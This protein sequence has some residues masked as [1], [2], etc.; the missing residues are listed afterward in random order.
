MGVLD[1]ECFPGSERQLLYVRSPIFGQTPWRAV[2]SAVY[3]TIIEEVASAQGLRAPLPSGA[4]AHGD[5]GDA[6]EYTPFPTASSWRRLF[7]GLVVLLLPVGRASPACISFRGGM[8][9][10]GDVRGYRAC[11]PVIRSASNFASAQPGWLTPPTTL[12]PPPCSSR[13]GSDFSL[14]RMA[15][16]AR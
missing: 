3:R 15:M 11:P 1:V 5:G 7:R 14:D 10:F 2:S 4:F 13:P 16:C 12:A 8:T 6:R 9:L